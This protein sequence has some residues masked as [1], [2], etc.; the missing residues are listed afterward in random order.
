MRWPMPLTE[1]TSS[2]KRITVTPSDKLVRMPES[3]CGAAAGKITQIS[4]RIQGS[5]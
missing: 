1:P 3:I 5:R 4:R 2:L